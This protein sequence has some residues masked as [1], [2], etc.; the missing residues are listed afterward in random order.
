[1]HRPQRARLLGIQAPEIRGDTRVAGYAAKE[2]LQHLVLDRDVTVRTYKG[3]PLGAFS[4]YLV[5]L[6]VDDVN[7]N[8]WMLDHGFAVVYTRGMREPLWPQWLLDANKN[9]R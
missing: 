4:R 6:V 8:E 2:A 1:M 3:E 9:R 7:V 5:E